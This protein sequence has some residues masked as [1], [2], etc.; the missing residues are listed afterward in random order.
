MLI[1]EI[2]FFIGTLLG[3]YR[4]GDILP[5][6]HDAD[7]SFLLSSDTSKAFQELAKSG[8]AAA[9]IKAR[10]KN[11]VVDFV[12]WRAEYTRTR[13]IGK[14]VLHK[15]YPVEVLEKDNVVTRYHH[16]LQSFPQSWVVPPKRVNFHGVS[17]SVPNSPA[18]LLAHR[19]LY[20]FGAFGVQFPYKWK[21]WVPCSLR[22]ANTC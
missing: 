10:F 19:Y 18:R 1:I 13:G 6:D 16:K 21:C 9:G 11:V 14:V 3:A 7:I 12:P 15:A 4:L 5:H 22:K 17:V 8:I 20:T 2:Y